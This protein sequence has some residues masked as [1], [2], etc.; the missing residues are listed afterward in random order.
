MKTIA[1]LILSVIIT[2]TLRDV[3]TINQ[4][5]R[6]FLGFWQAQQIEVIYSLPSWH[7]DVKRH[8]LWKAFDIEQLAFK[9]L[10]R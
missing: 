7:R 8:I 1:I 6:A 2:L 9:T 3:N 4:A 5:N 10:V